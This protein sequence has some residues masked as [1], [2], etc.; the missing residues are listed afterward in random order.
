[1]RQRLRGR[2]IPN[3]C[4]DGVGH[5]RLVREPHGR[6]RVTHAVRGAEPP[7]RRVGSGC[8]PAPAPAGDRRPGVAAAGDDRGRRHRPTVRRRADRPHPHRRG[9]P[10]AAGAVPRHPGTAGERRRA[11][12]AR[13][14]L[15]PRV[16]VQR[17]V[18]RELHRPGRR[19]GRER[20]PGLRLGPRPR[21]SGLRARA[22]GHRPA[23]REPQ[24]RRPGLRP[25]RLPVHRDRRRRQRRRSVRQ[26]P[27]TRHP[28]RQAAAHR[29]RRSER[30][31]PYGI[32]PDN[33]FV[34]REGARPEIWAYGLRNPWRF[35]FDR[36]T[37]DL[38]IGDVG[39]SSWE[40]IDRVGPGARRRQLRLERDGGAGLLR[41]ELGL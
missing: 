34:G 24:R 21:R 41:A 16:R 25:G 32:P 39:Q 14:R 40:E 28:A 11:G 17:P 15:P 33:P 1:M 4:G 20:V 9:G 10:P 13:P 31:A 23:V 35:S 22:A 36:E 26:R 3:R 5:R 12:A 27:A 8:G 7:A 29:R 38:W 18:L 6:C 19:H 37:G 30:G 2:R